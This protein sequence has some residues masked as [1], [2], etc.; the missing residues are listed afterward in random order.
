MQPQDKWEKYC[1]Q[2]DETNP[3]DRMYYEGFMAALEEFYKDMA[4]A[5]PKEIVKESFNGNPDTNIRIK[6]GAY[7][8]AIYDTKTSQALIAKKWG[9]K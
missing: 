9:L 5:G 1:I 7:N 6:R 4:E 2:G 3:T 8:R